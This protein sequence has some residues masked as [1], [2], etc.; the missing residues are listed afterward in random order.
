MSW[1]LII[2]ML[3]TRPNAAPMPV[4]AMTTVP[5]FTSGE[6]CEG[7]GR[8]ISSALRARGELIWY[9]MPVR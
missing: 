5:G 3:G 4:P 6:A 2:I 9:C 8:R 1:A 7:E